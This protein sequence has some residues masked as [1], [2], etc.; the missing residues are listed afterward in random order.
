MLSREAHRVLRTDF[1]TGFGR[2]M[3]P[4]VSQVNPRIK[5]MNYKTGVR[6]LYFRGDITNKR[7]QFQIDLQQKDDDIRELFWEQWLEYKAFLTNSTGIVFHWEDLIFTDD[8]RPICRISVKQ[9]GVNLYDK[10]TWP[11]AFAF[12]KTCFL[13]VDEFWGDVQDVFKALDH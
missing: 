4:H 1:W 9:E 10:S 8:G 2:V 12:L 13:Q 6:G 7:V 5:W 11:E 3:Q